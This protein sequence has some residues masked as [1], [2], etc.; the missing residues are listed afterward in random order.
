M[1]IGAMS[2]A[3]KMKLKYSWMSCSLK[4][5]HVLLPSHTEGWHMLGMV[6]NDT[7]L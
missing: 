6:Y 7:G 5:N 3:E 2:S 1:Y 4:T